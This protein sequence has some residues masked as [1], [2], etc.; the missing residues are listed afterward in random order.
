[1]KFFGEIGRLTFSTDGNKL[2]CH[3]CGRYF[4]N[5]CSSHVPRIHHM[6]AYD[7]KELFGLCNTIGL[8]GRETKTKSAQAHWPA[9]THHAGKHARAGGLLS[10][11][12]VRLQARLIRGQNSKGKPNR[13]HVAISENAKQRFELWQQLRSDGA[14]YQ[15]MAKQFRYGSV[16]GFRKH[17]SRL[18]LRFAAK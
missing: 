13:A 9:L 1:M 16:D 5:L 8:T 6:S 2:Q 10:S 3:L 17:F 11:E 12:P 14:S 4:R 7:Y 18:K 15:E